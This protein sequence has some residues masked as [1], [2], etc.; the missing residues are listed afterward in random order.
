MFNRQR[1][2]GNKN[3][4]RFFRFPVFIIVLGFLLSYNPT[5]SLSQILKGHEETLMNANCFSV[6]N[7]VII[8]AYKGVR[9]RDK[10]YNG[11]FNEIRIYRLAC[12]NFVFGSDYKEYFNNLNFRKG[13]LIFKGYIKPILE[14]KFTFVDT[15]AKQDMVYAYW[16]GSSEGLSIGPFPVKVRNMEVWWTYEKIMSKINSL[17]VRFPENV[18]VQEIGHSVRHKP[19]YGITIGKGKPVLAL[20]GAIHAGESGPELI[21]P[22]LKKVL[23]SYTSLLD[24]VSIIAIPIINIDNRIKEVHGVP[25][26]IRKNHNGVDL[27]R[28]FP[29][30]WKKIEFTYGYKTTDPNS[31][32]YRGPFPASEAETRAVMKFLKEKDPRVLFSFHALASICGGTLL[33]SEVSKKDDE[34]LT[35]CYRFAN[36]YW[37]GI[38]SVLFEGHKISFSCTSGSLPTWCYKK[39]G[40]PAFDVEA[41]VDTEDRAQLVVDKTDLAILKKYQRKNLRGFINL[42]QTFKINQ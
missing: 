38:D 13:K 30:D 36:L 27:N 41:P 3:F 34:Y 17:K 29:A 9:Y 4:T 7:K 15:T 26:Y 40:I 31:G 12:P 21:I 14:N 20:V 37:D 32:T 35:K 42:L 39:L 18:K 11:L 25:W 19:I 23:E 5:C 2:R 8:N 33:A 24:K 16:I 6:N 22:I 10:K 1:D 28:N